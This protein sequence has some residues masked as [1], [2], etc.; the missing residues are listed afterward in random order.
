MKKI[1]HEKIISV[2]KKIL[3]W[4]KIIL[5]FTAIVISTFIV[6]VV[7]YVIIQI[8]A[9]KEY[10]S[11]TKTEVLNQFVD[12]KFVRDSEECYLWYEKNMLGMQNNNA[13]T[14]ESVTSKAN[15]N[16]YNEID[17][18]AACKN[19]EGCLYIKKGNKIIYEGTDTINEL[20]M[21]KDGVYYLK[22]KD[23]KLYRYLL[24]EKNESVVIN[25][26]IKSF[27]LYGNYIVYND[28]ND[29]LVRFY[30]QEK[31]SLELAYNIQRFFVG[32]KIVAQNGNQ[33]V[34]IALD[35][36]NII[37][38]KKNAL[39]M[40]YYDGQ[41]YYLELDKGEIKDSNGKY[42]LYS[43]DINGSGKEKV[44][45]SENMIRGIY[46]VG[47]KIVVDSME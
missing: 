31:K 40:G 10:V 11:S 5:I 22:E 8:S 36:N 35:G 28:Q 47:D 43:C 21:K 26:K 24:T 39:L 14:G 33:I 18:I 3:G 45:T 30:L 25:Q 15:T 41:V 20:I 38:I 19:K 32:S 29:K 9:S 1:N 6:T 2:G 4:I 44:E 46:C 27:A 17:G 16:Y 23:K 13:L 7:T 37:A 34:S 12:N 42:I